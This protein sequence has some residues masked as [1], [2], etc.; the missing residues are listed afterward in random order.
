MPLLPSDLVAQAR[1]MIQEIKPQALRESLD[2]DLVIIDV[3]EVDEYDRG[4]IPGVVNVP[5][6]I[7]EFEL[8]RHPILNCDPHS[9]VPPCKVWGS[10]MCGR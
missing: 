1:Q 8:A 6:G 5:R 4:S 9:P 2:D 3:R 10:K 7:L